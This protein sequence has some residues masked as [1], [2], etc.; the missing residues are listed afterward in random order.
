[1]Y[2]QT[3]NKW[4]HRN[5]N[6]FKMKSLEATPGEHSTDALQ[7]TVILGTSHI[8]R[9]ILQSAIRSLSHRDTP[10][11]QEEKYQVE[12]SCHKNNETVIIHLQTTRMLQKMA[13]RNISM[14]GNNVVYPC[15][16]GLRDF[17]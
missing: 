2:D 15:S 6:I 7:A 14:W 11:F 12:K 10:L 16:P 17:Y 8:I 13:E 5:S 3:S 4:S 9:K 1:M